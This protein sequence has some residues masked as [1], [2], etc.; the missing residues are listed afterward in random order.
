MAYAVFAMVLLGIV[1]F[2]AFKLHEKNE[3]LEICRK[4]IREEREAAKEQAMAKAKERELIWD[5]INAIHLYAALSKE[6]TRSRSV[7]EKQEAILRIAEQ[8]LEQSREQE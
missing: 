1:I 5:R 2:L 4:K 6:E 3:Q 7:R 8:L